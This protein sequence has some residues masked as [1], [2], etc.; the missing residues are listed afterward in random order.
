MDKKLEAFRAAFE[1][2]TPS[3]GCA[4]GL[5]GRVIRGRVDEDF[6]RLSHDTTREIVM[7]VGDD[8]LESFVGK[9]GYQIVRDVLRYTDEHVRRLLDDKYQLKL[10]VFGVGK[11]EVKLAT[12]A[13][14][15]EVA[16]LIYPLIAEKLRGQAET[17]RTTPF[18]EIEEL[19]GYKF[20]D[21]D[22]KGDA[23]TGYMTYARY[24]SAPDTLS[25]ARAFLF[26]TLH[27]REPY[28]G[29]GYAFNEREYFALNHAVSDLGDH[30][31]LPIEVTLI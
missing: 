16:G 3:P 30:L 6:L 17:L 26:H 4:D 15:I 7:L 21:A 31:L 29:N 8:G 18:E 1:S 11:T 19:A 10:V 5:Y 12:W 13:A 14:T 22:K 25:N 28:L 24:Q 20:Y 23:H 9:T 2:G 27:L